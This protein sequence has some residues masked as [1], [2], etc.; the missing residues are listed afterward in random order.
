[1]KPPLFARRL[2]AEEQ[3]AVTA[4]LHAA[5]AFTLRRCQILRASAHGQRP[6]EIARTLGC[7]VQAV[8]N[9]IHAFH[10]EGLACLTPKSRRPKTVQPIFDPPK[11]ARLQAIL[12]QSPR[13]FNKPTSVWTLALA[14]DVCFEQGITERR[15][16]VERIRVTLHRLGVGWQ[17]A[18]HWITSPDPAYARKKSGVTA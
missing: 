13:T 1:M 8:R 3:A 16:S 11:A 10:A 7:S 4:G 2:T 18:K 5:D 9:V 17:R 12:H 6:A 14:A 15:V